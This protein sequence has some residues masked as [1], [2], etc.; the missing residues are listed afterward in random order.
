MK[1]WGA[2]VLGCWGADVL[3]CWS[4]IGAVLAMSAIGV[5][6]APAPVWS[7]W[8]GPARDG[9]AS[10]FTLPAAWPAQLT[11]RWQ[12]AVGLGHASPV[13]SGTRV[14]LH[15]RQS[16]RE[17]VAAYDLQSG[18]LLWQDGVDA[19][20]TMNS[21]ATG[22]GPGPKS[23]PA[24]A[25]GRVF[26]L[27]ISGIFSAHDLATGK[28][29][30]RKNAPPTP[31]E[32]GTASSPLVDGSN[33]IAFL[34]GTGAGALTA[35]DVAT[36]AVKWRWTG[37]GP[38]YASPILATF[39]GIKQ[40]VTQSQN[41]MVGVD[42]AKGQ[43]LW[44]VPVKTPYEQN[45]VTPLI[46]GDLLIYA[47]LENPTIALRVTTNAGKW[48]TAPA[49][50]N[51]DVAMYMSSPAVTGNVIYGLST[52]SR[53][54]FFA[55]DLKTG[56]TLWLTKGREAENASIVRAGDYLLMATT[57]SELV[58]V[59]ANPARYEEVKRYTVAD[60]AMWAHPAFAGRTVI[61]KDVDTLVA[62]GF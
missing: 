2:G 43:L 62:W 41:K 39:A 16:N 20:Y 28:L 58:V 47:G 35:M 50:R 34:G 1:C 24:I 5:A 31:P 49:W 17:V 13:V 15:S 32:F 44:E 54:Q 56:K 38:G 33:V 57:N 52:K 10:S 14:I 23:T 22:H 60:S 6:Q 8:R 9:V 4:A 40:V 21:A 46:A 59:K 12:A 19:P 3:K 53:G 7:Q 45:S 37:D 11:K 30:W 29:L 55:I 26:T 27:G 61:I 36:G 48:T 42:A 18:K 51:E 25:D